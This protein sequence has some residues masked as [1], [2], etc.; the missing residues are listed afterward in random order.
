LAPISKPPST[1]PS[2]LFITQLNHQPKLEPIAQSQHDVHK[3]KNLLQGKPII[4]VGGGPGLKRID[5]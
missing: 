3:N 5:L 4:F 2:S 1:G